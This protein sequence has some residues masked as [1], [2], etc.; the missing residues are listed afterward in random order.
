MEPR[1]DAVVERLEAAVGS[2]TAD[3]TQIAWIETLHG[4]AAARGRRRQTGGE[5]RRL[6]VLVRAG[7][8]GRWG[9]FRTDLGDLHALEGAVRQAVAASRAEP[10]AEAPFELPTGE[11]PSSGEGAAGPAPED[12]F[13]PEVAA[14]DPLSGRDRLRALA[15]KGEG[16]WLRWAR[17]RVV[18]V[19]SRGLTRS[20]E[21]TTV[22]MR[23]RAGRGPGVG[24]ARGATRRLGSLDGEGIF[25]R[26]RERRSDEA[27]DDPPA[28][29]GGLV[30]APEAA[31]CLLELLNRAALSSRS[32]R[33]GP[34][35]LK[36]RLGQTVAPP[37][38]TLRDDG[39]DPGG[40][41]FPFDLDGRTKRPVTLIGE[42][43]LR[44]PAV[45]PAL[46]AELGLSPTPHSLAPGEAEATNLFLEP[47]QTPAAEL[48]AAVGDGLWIGGLQ[49]LACHDL[50]GLAFRA[51]A[52]G[53]RRISGGRLGPPL[54]AWTWEDRLDRVLGAVLAVGRQ[55]V[56]RPTAD[57]LLGAVSAPAL[58]LAP[59][60]VPPGAAA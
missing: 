35:G 33:D 14:L 29:P 57:G 4:E 17:G 25:E 10:R 27:S 15:G 13:D 3:A 59:P 45:D 60:P 48:P 43:V 53:V 8:A 28:S 49:R 34:R 6:T 26:A 19:N 11:R 9:A 40:L 1:L 22:E 55:T 39:T 31:A 12:L 23:V 42:G 2:S 16:A 51:R 36:E 21:A 54:P 38:V 56:L 18:I 41:P 20:A 7:A 37:L 30:L 32:F 46:V 24:R 5:D 50:G 58:A 44:T 52:V 47:G